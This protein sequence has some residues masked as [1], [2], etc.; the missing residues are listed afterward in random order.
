MVTCQ[1]A[2]VIFMSQLPQYAL[3]CMQGMTHFGVDHMIPLRQN[4]WC[5]SFCYAW[6]EALRLLKEALVRGAAGHDAFACEAGNSHEQPRTSDKHR[7]TRNWK[8]RSGRRSQNVTKHTK[9]RT[10]DFCSKVPHDRS[11]F[12]RA[13]KYVSLPKCTRCIYR[14]KR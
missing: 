3:K 14:T 9:H 2:E 4:L 7:K 11:S 5:F 8:G 13:S 12:G 6:G 1:C 10:F